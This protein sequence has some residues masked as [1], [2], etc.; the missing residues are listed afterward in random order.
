MHTD[1][2]ANHTPPN[3]RDA[4]LRADVRRVGA[5]LGR[6]LVRQH[7]QELLDLVEQVRKL[8]KQSRE[9]AGSRS[10]T[11]R[12]RRSGRSWPR[13]PSRRPPTWS[14]PSPPTSSWPTAPSRCTGSGRCGA[15]PATEGHLAAVVAEIASKLGR[16]RAGRRDRDAGRAAG[17]HRASHRGQPPVRAAQ[18]A[19]RR[20]HPG[21][22][23][24]ARQRP[25]GHARTASWPRSST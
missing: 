16:G 2:P 8:T 25:P 24:R 3:D 15:G 9:A 19:G 7:G 4:E 5:L 10:G 14:A 18:A 1:A 6:T 11:R 23:D 17:L 12:P 20:R 22:P 13:C 21:R